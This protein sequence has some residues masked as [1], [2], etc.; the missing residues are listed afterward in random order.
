ML[1]SDETII[2]K[3]V[4]TNITPKNPT[5]IEDDRLSSELFSFRVYFEVCLTFTV[6]F[7]TYSSAIRDA[8]SSVIFAVV[9][10]TYSVVVRVIV[11][12]EVVI[13]VDTELTVTLTVTLAVS[14]GVGCIVKFSPLT[15]PLTEVFAT[16]R[17]PHVVLGDA[18][19][20]AVGGYDV[21]KLTVTFIHSLE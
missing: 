6:M 4:A 9:V 20:I 18:F 1:I 8:S 7:L 21:V 10:V 11:E 12:T 16:G 15:V 14:Q 5:T 19:L 2:A 13:F 3:G 17:V